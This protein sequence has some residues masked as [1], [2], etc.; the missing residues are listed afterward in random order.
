MKRPNKPVECDPKGKTKVGEIDF[1]EKRDLTIFGEWSPGQNW[2]YYGPEGSGPAG[3][4]GAIVEVWIPGQPTPVI[5]Q[6]YKGT[7]MEIKNGYAQC[8]EVTVRMDDPGPL[9]DNFHNPKNPMRASL[10]EFH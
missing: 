8:V 5:S 1:G 10:L 9:G 3:A 2:P 7:H 6:H 4:Y